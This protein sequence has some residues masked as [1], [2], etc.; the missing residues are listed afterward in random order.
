MPPTRVSL[1]TF[2]TT[3][4]YDSWHLRN[5]TAT[6]VVVASTGEYNYTATN[7]ESS[8]EPIFAFQLSSSSN[9]TADTS[10]SSTIVVASKRFDTSSVQQIQR[11]DSVPCSLT[12]TADTGADAVVLEYLSNDSTTAMAAGSNSNSI[13]LTIRMAGPVSRFFYVAAGVAV[14]FLLCLFA[15]GCAVSPPRRSHRGERRRLLP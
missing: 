3:W 7:T 12:M 10:L 9:A 4:E 14:A 15:C 2:R 8:L 11:C 5:G 6:P 13:K 1:Y